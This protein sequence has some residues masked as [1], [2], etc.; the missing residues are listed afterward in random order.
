[1]NRA[2]MLVSAR[3]DSRLREEVR[4]RLRP[5]PE[6]LRLER[7]H[8]VELLDWS[9]L[10]HPSSVRHR[11]ARVSVM[12]AAAGFRRLRD[13]DVVFSDCE[14]IGVPLAL[15]MRAL[16]RRIPH[17]MLA[18]H[19]TTPAKRPFLHLLRG[20]HGVG[21]VLVH[22]KQQLD[23]GVRLGIPSERMHLIP[24]FADTEFWSPG[25]RR[26]ERLVVS[27]GADHRDYTTLAAACDGLDVEVFIAQGSTH[28]A[29]ARQQAPTRWPANIR[30][31]FADYQSLR[32]WY[33]R[34]AVVVVP[35]IPN[36]FQAGVTT[37]LEAM[38]MGKAVVVS[39]TTAQR[40]IVADGETGVCVAPGNP[41]ALRLT[42]ARLLDDEEERKRL[43]GNAR[44]AA[45]AH[46]SLDAYTKRL[47]DHLSEV[48]ATG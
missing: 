24:Y 27:A 39:A 33:A 26:E 8:G 47:A 48:A 20:R 29:R 34:A 22:S 18:H 44:R 19:L 37:V 31:A 16:G 11:T 3:A 5:C 32:D 23:A 14:P 12:Q 28:N 21:R 35:L 41:R 2:L 36:D 45:E 4:D 46:F 30:S 17:L 15:G 1:M 42:L 10:A 6:Y 13:F 9:V 40:D 38:A 25:G 43:G 7:D